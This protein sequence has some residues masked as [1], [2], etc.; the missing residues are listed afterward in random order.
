MVKYTTI[1]SSGNAQ[2]MADEFVKLFINRKFLL[3]VF[4]T[5]QLELSIPHQDDVGKRMY[6]RTENNIGMD[7]ATISYGQLPIGR[8]HNWAVNHVCRY[9]N[10]WSMEANFWLHAALLAW[11]I[12]WPVHMYKTTKPIFIHL[13]CTITNIKGLNRVCD[14]AWLFWWPM[15]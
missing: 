4:I 3:S 10:L 1:S 9:I 2:P 12:F 14:N 15:S 8:N 6:N 11:P 7:N 13:R 5:H